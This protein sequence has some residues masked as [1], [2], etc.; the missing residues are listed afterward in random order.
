MN[1]WIFYVNYPFKIFPVKISKKEMIVLSSKPR[2]RDFMLFV[3]LET[4][5]DV[6]SFW[7]R[8]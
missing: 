6:L 4:K 1:E 8:T 7:S 3:C 2:P 5:S